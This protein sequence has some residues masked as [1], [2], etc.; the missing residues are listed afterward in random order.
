MREFKVNTYLMVKLIRGKSIIFVKG[1][2][3]KQCKFLLLINP[4]EKDR[5]DE[6]DSIDEADEL[7]NNK[8]EKDM[9]PQDLGMAPEQEFWGHCSNLQAWVELNY[10][11]RLLHRNLAFPLLKELTKAGD[12][13]AKRAFKEEIAR[14]FLSGHLPVSIYL[15]NEGYLEYL[16]DDEFSTLIEEFETILKNPNS[17]FKNLDIANAW[18]NL[19]LV[20]CK[21]GMLNKAIKAS[22][23]A[24]EIKPDLVQAWNNLGHIHNE[25]GDYDKAINYLNKA[26]ELNPKYFLPWNNLAL[27]Y[28][29]KGEF[30][31]AIDT[32]ERSLQIEPNFANSMCHLGFAFHKKGESNKAIDIIKKALNLKNDYYKGWEYL[33]IIYDEIGENDNT[34]IAYKKLVELKPNN[35]NI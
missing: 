1:I 25:K 19:S 21:K 3:F 32:S 14:R 10:D 30:D 20:F 22:K 29:Q 28:I 27:A 23:Q 16:N 5:H 15:M 18:N 7:Y 2:Q 11:T 13:Q 26:L 34:I 12:L 9:K 35:S 24:L 4:H 6:I 31:K 33:G 17:C 8:L